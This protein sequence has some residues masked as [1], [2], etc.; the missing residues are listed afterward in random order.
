MTEHRKKVVFIGMP[1]SG[2]SSTI[3]I[4]LGREECQTGQTFMKGGL[5]KKFQ[6]YDS[7]QSKLHNILT[8]HYLCI[9]FAI[10]A[11]VYI[12]TYNLKYFILSFVMFYSVS[13][14][15]PLTESNTNATEDAS[16][17]N[18]WQEE[19]QFGRKY[20]LVDS[21]ND[22]K[23]FLERQNEFDVFAF[24]CPFTRY[25]VERKQYLERIVH[26]IG[27]SFFHRCILIFTQCS[28]E[29]EGN[30]ERE[31]EAVA[32]IDENIKRMKK[33]KIICPSVFQNESP[34]EF[35]N[36]FDELLSN[37]EYQ[38]NRRNKCPIFIR[39]DCT[40]I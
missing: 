33:R 27:D 28:K 8:N 1:G 20:L 4:L 19:Y 37:I 40:L 32:K 2:K 26:A 34:Y 14:S 13:A 18:D 22:F 23:E 16:L 39:S 6:Q 21:S 5:T 10:F 36:R 11:N 15:Q 24:V 25:T 29:Q 3:N 35:Q 9:P 31:I 7:P 17:R 38:L 12:T 30:I